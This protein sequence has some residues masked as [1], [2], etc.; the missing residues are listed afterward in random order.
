[1]PIEGVEK[2]K[3]MSLNLFG[4]RRN[5]NVGTVCIHPNFYFFSPRCLLLLSVSTDCFRYNPVSLFK[6]FVSLSDFVV[7]PLS[8]RM[9]AHTSHFHQPTIA[10]PPSSA[11]TK[12]IKDASGNTREPRNKSSLRNPRHAV[13]SVTA[14]LA[15]TRPRAISP[16]APPP[17]SHTSPSNAKLARENVPLHSA[18]MFA[19]SRRSGTASPAGNLLSPVS[20][21]LLSPGSQSLGA[22]L[23]APAVSPRMHSRGSILV[24]A[25]AIEDEESRRLSE[26]AFLDF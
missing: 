26:L 10:I 21:S 8:Y 5:T 13:T 9:R 1:M 18:T 20:A 11:F 16:T 6:S 15:G 3:K 25:G 7:Y 24:E 23:R 14:G 12:S 2:E 4:R 19:S 22:R 17:F